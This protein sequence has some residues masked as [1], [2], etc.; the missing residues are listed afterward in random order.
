MWDKSK[1]TWAVGIA[2]LTHHVVRCGGKNTETE[3][4]RMATIHHKS[5]FLK[6]QTSLYRERKNQVYRGICIARTKLQQKNRVTDMVYL[7]IL[8]ALPN[9]VKRRCVVRIMG[10][11]VRTTES[12][13]DGLSYIVKFSIHH[14]ILWHCWQCPCCLG[15]PFG[16]DVCL[17]MHPCI[18]MRIRRCFLANQLGVTLVRFSVL[19]C[20]YDLRSS[21]LIIS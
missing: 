13:C 5:Y 3:C 21:I 17:E 11:C 8:K 1:T 14:I 19:L 7:F 9:K 16:L 6:T 12:I 15:R 2:Q 10:Y 4:R 18:I 20:L